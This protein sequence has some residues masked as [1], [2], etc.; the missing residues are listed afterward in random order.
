MY[1]CVCVRVCVCIQLLLLAGT[2]ICH[3]EF[4]TKLAWPAHLY[5]C[6]SSSSCLGC[7]VSE[8]LPGC[9]A[10]MLPV[11][12]SHQHSDIDFPVNHQS[13]ERHTQNEIA[14]Q[15]RLQTAAH[16]MLECLKASAWYATIYVH[17]HTYSHTYRHTH[18]L[19]K[20][21]TQAKINIRCIA[22]AAA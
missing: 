21:S 16:A 13:T 8:W 4:I 15:L 10:A 7:N 11:C 22:A 6:I 12:Q 3:S 5:L 1:A 9:Q 2:A 14:M 18:M 19:S 20:S 17:T